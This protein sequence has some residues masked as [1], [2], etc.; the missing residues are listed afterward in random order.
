M[1][2][3]LLLVLCFYLSGCGDSSQKQTYYTQLIDEVMAIK[4]HKTQDTQTHISE[5][6]QAL[7]SRAHTSGYE[8]ITPKELSLHLDEY[9]IIATLPRGIYNLG[10]IPE[11]RHFE[12]ALSP[13]LNEDGSDWNWTADA[14]GR[15]QEDFIKLLGENKEAKILFY[16][17]GENI[18]SPVGS[19]HVGLLWAKHLGYTHLYRLIG[20]QNAWK[21][22]HLPL[23]TQV[24]HCC[25]M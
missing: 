25:Q 12:F 9:I 16:D 13:S 11:A 17:S 10:L 24:P 21:D 1:K 18:F 14:L 23:S 19:A 4:E 22:M 6:A 7:V 3:I 15:T 2:K 5:D 8:L 20:G